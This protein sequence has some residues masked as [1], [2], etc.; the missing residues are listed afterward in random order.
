ME[1]KSQFR[2]LELVAIDWDHVIL[3]DPICHGVDAHDATI[4]VRINLIEHRRDVRI[5]RIEADQCR[6]EIVE[7]SAG[8][9]ESY[10]ITNAKRFIMACDGRVSAQEAE[11]I[12]EQHILGCIERNY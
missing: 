9:L 1:M 11:E 10:Q 7:R 12:A 2:N 5:P 6:V 4:V 8:S 3:R